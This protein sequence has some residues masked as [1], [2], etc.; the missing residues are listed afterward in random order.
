MTKK[1]F[2]RFVTEEEALK[3]SKEK[4]IIIKDDFQLVR[5]GIEWCLV[6]FISLSVIFTIM[7]GSLYVFYLTQVIDTAI[8]SGRTFLGLGEGQ[9]EVQQEVGCYFG[10]PTVCLGGDLD[11]TLTYIPI[12]P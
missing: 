11:T 8:L 5:L 7:I 1:I 2:Y 6:T 3:I 12:Q 10:A 9:G 4:N